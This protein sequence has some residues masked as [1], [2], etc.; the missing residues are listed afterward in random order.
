[1]TAMRWLVLLLLGLTL[2]AG[3]VAETAAA[4]QAEDELPIF[5]AHIHYNRDAWGLFSVD[6]ALTILDQAGV[7]KAF[8]SSTPDDG[9]LMLYQR[10]PDRIVPSLRLYRTPGDQ[11]TWTRDGSMLPYI[12]ERLATGT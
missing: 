4:R 7:R 6:D 2:L 1:M 8:V 5:D 12:E 11:V 3:E 9:T 10:A